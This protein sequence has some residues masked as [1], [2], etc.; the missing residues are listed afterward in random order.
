MSDF[1]FGSL[2]KKVIALDPWY[3]KTFILTHFRQLSG[4]MKPSQPLIYIGK[5]CS[6]G[7][8]SSLNWRQEIVISYCH[9]NAST[10]TQEPSKVDKSIR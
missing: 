4:D 5:I 7:V 8:T 2:I 3:I 9:L 6:Q 10:A 1:C